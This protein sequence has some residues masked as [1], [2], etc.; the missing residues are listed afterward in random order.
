[1]QR[2]ERE[3]SLGRP[4]REDFHRTS[5]SIPALDGHAE[6]LAQAAHDAR[7]MAMALDVYCDLLREP[8]VLA[9]P[10]SHYGS[11][12][13]HVAATSR[14]LVEKLAALSAA[15]GWDAG[16]A[17]PKGHWTASATKGIERRD[18]WAHRTQIRPI[19]NFAAEVLVNRNVLTAIVGP[20]IAL[21][22][23][24]KGSASPVRLAGEDLTRILVNLVKNSAEA[25]CS[26]GRVHISLWEGAGDSH[27]VSWLTLNVE[28]NGP[29][30]PDRMLADVFEHGEDAQYHPNTVCGEQPV[31]RR[32]LGLAITQSLVEGAGGRIHA[33]NRDPV[34]A[35]IQIELPVR[36]LAIP[37]R[38]STED[39]VS[40]N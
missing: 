33:A 14:S 5:R 8:G 32:G 31:S 13:K 39:C 1:M 36:P 23:D 19:E 3:T 24:V 17:E 22:I 30:F 20:T 2:M 25:M 11:E 18:H 40:L 29:G 15:D 7:N 27:G 35:C 6:S 38:R 28:D 34:G 4:E 26:V 9:T 37:I 21:T 10:F 16:S 12:L